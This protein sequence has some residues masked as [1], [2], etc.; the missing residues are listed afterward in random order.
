MVKPSFSRLMALLLQVIAALMFAVPLLALTVAE[1]SVQGNY[2]GD[3]ALKKAP[4]IL[5][6]VI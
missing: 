5:K 6:E 4:L 2:A 3:R 1:R